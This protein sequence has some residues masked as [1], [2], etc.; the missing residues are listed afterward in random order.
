MTEFSTLD[1]PSLSLLD[2]VTQPGLEE[3]FLV[4]GF[5]RFDVAQTMTN[6][7]SLAHQTRSCSS[8]Q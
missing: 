2:D 6:S 4:L 8:L 7:P 1:T 3:D 5:P